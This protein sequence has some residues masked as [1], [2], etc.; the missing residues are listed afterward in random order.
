MEFTLA[1]T[2]ENVLSDEICEKIIEF[3]KTA[4][5][6][7]WSELERKNLAN[8]INKY[9]KSVNSEEEYRVL[10]KFTLPR[11]EDTEDIYAPIIHY[12]N[13]ANQEKWNYDISGIELMQI[14]R[15]PVGGHYHWHM[16]AGS[17]DS[18]DNTRKLSMTAYVNDPKEY[19]GGNLMIDSGVSKIEV[20]N[21]KKGSACFFPA[22]A[23]HKVQSV[24]K[25][26]RWVIVAWFR[27]P[28]LR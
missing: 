5:D 13:L 2:Y 7:S 27:G 4:E 23:V 8:T 9:E 15:Y 3:T 12:M 25:G 14:L 6:V 11:N 17:D 1:C 19:E 16:D 28:P 22:W 24:T 26:V 10:K 21:M 18:P 20:A